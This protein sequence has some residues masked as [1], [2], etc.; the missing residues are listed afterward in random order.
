MTLIL[1]V[2]GVTKAGYPEVLMACWAAHGVP[3]EPPETFKVKS[4]HASKHK[5]KRKIRFKVPDINFSFHMHHWTTKAYR[6]SQHL[7]ATGLML[8]HLTMVNVIIAFFLTNQGG[9]SKYLLHQEHVD[10]AISFNIGLLGVLYLVLVQH[11]IF[12][13]IPNMPVRCVFLGF[14]EIIFQWFALANILET[15][16]NILS[17]SILTLCVS[18][19]LMFPIIL[20]K[21]LDALHPDVQVK[22]AHKKKWD[23]LVNMDSVADFSEVEHTLE[24]STRPKLGDR[25]KSSFSKLFHTAD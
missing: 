2:L 23:D 16:S 9:H 11:V 7:A 20:I 14:V 5:D 12:Q 4:D 19:W 8:H 1:F 10:A 13:C 24:E 15:N 17:T 22:I 18:H 25:S 3:I 6:A 21:L